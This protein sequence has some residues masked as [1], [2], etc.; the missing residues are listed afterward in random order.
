MAKRGGGESLG[1][2]V[3]ERLRSAILNGSEL[4]PGQR[5]KPAEIGA[6]YDVSVSV[7]REALGILAAKGLVRI[8]RNRGFHVVP[9]SLDV[10]EQLTEARLVT[11][12]GALR[13]SV[14]RGDVAWESAVLAAHHRLASEPIF[15]DGDPPVRNEDWARAH[16]DFHRTLI[17]GCDNA[18]LLDLAL[19]LS[20]TAELY[21]AWAAAGGRETDR[22]VEGEHRALLDAALAHD[23]DKAV[24]L[25]DDHI[26]RTCQILTDYASTFGLADRKAED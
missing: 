20:D 17:E 10:L 18:V 6:R 2:L 12:G 24:K 19:R 21:R 7:V 25:F 3:Y 11:E 8:D 26:T 5:L 14:E 13:L 15:H 4:L 9:L 22:D 23:A 1:V 16:L